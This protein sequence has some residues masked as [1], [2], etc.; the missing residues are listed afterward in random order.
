[1]LT[2]TVAAQRLVRLTIEHPQFV[3]HYSFPTFDKVLCSYFSYYA[4]IFIYVVTYYLGLIIVILT[5]YYCRVM[6]WTD[7]LLSG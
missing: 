7:N 6:T 4:F 3:Q 2:S 1:M 5:D